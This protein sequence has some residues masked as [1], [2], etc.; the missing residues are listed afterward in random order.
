VLRVVKSLEP[1]AS[2]LST[3]TWFY[4]KRCLLAA[5]EGAAKHTVSL[6]EAGW[7]ELLGFLEAAEAAGRGMP[8]AFAGGGGGGGGMG[9]AGGGDGEGRTV[10]E[11]ARLLRW[12][13]LRVWEER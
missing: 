5:A 6:R 11:E 1:P 2:K 8:A 13:L 9:G 12:L 10:A 3:D 7:Q 4:A